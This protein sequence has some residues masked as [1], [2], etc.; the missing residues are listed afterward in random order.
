MR[1]EEGRR[2]ESKRERKEEAEVRVSEREEGGS[3]GEI[4]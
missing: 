2:G 3:R 4:K 1:G